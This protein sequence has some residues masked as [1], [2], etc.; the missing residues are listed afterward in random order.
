MAKFSVPHL[1]FAKLGS[2][3]FLPDLSLALTTITLICSARH[4]SNARHLGN[5]LAESH[6]EEATLRLNAL[7]CRER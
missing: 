4:L 3:A 7:F 6:D 5:A 2:L 1:S